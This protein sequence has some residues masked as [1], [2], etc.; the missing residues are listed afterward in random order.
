LKMTTEFYEILN[1]FNP[2][3]I[4]FEVH[5]LHEK[6]RPSGTLV[7]VKIPVYEQSDTLNAPIVNV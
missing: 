2:K 7:V 1:Q 3:P 4:S 5:D 6:G